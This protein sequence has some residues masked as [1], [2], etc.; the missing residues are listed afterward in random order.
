MSALR[1]YRTLIGVWVA[2]IALLARKWQWPQ[3]LIDVLA[4]Q[5][6]PFEAESCEP[7][8]GVLHLAAWRAGTREAG[9]SGGAL[10]GTFPDHVGVPLGLDIDTV[11]QQDPIDWHSRLAAQPA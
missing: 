7:L 8:A 10:I 6:D 2:L 5:H 9:L 11:L 4:S 3:L 1:P